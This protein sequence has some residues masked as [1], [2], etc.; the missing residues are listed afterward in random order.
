V[1]EH[2]TSRSGSPAGGLPE[3]STAS[4]WLIVGLLL[5]AIAGSSL[6][7]LP[8]AIAWSRSGDATYIADGDG[9]LYLAWSR[10]AVLG[11]E[12]RL[13]DAIHSSSG[14][15]M[16]P[17]LPF[18]PL[19]RLARDLGLGMSGL[20]VV[21]RVV[22]GALIALG[23]FVAIRP[24][25]RRAGVALCLSAFV[26]CD[27]GMMFGQLIRRELEIV[28]SLAKGS[29]WFLTGVPR[30]MPHF[31]VV[32]PGLAMPALLFHFGAILRARQGGIPVWWV[33]AVGS[34]GLLFYVYFY[35]WTMVA[36]G[37]ALAVVC[38]RAGWR[39]YVLVLFGGLILGAPALWE[40]FQVREST[41]PDW[42]LR[43]NKFVAIGHFEELLWPKGLILGWL[44][45]AYW[46]F[47][48]RPELIYAWSCTGAGLFCLDH[49]IVTGLQIENEH[50]S[51]A[52]GV[53]FSVL[54]A[55][56]VAPAVE[57]AIDSTRRWAWRSTLVLVLV[58]QVALGF[59]LRVLETTRSDETRSIQEL[60]V[61]WREDP[62]FRE[63]PSG[64]VVAGEPESLFLAA[65][66]S[67]IMPLSCRLVEFA[68]RSDD[69]ELDERL[70]LNLYLMG[71]DR[72][73]ARRRVELPPGTLSWEAAARH[74]AERRDRQRSR[75]LAMIEAIWADPNPSIERFD[76]SWVVLPRATDCKHLEKVA[77][78]EH[79]GTYY[80]SW[81]L[82]RVQK[83]VRISDWVGARRANPT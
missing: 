82:I 65:G 35:Y 51:G 77:H 17:W 71:I 46:V 23:L 81:R 15:M 11:S 53:A 24:S 45:V 32:T 50:W 28:V 6:A 58:G 67:R 79:S 52:Y 7:A 34:F 73:E 70:L 62:S 27:S 61:R 39:L 22:S 43:T 54:L 44:T 18:V 56:L 40:Q 74:S 4:A 37:L 3:S 41:S 2:S 59:G 63:I 13:G 29:D 10:D 76:V 49:Q 9:L 66:L 19:A 12:D 78:L 68:A 48:K 5:L 42:L 25:T 1:S 30:L 83:K 57:R 8:H 47:R 20:G 33:L 75:R 72:T 14:P 80:R 36:I 21:W 60:Y 31:R 55:G 64:A 38:D 69:A 16:H 26:L